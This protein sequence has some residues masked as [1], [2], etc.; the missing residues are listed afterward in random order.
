MFSLRAICMKYFPPCPQFKRNVHLRVEFIDW[1]SAKKYQTLVQSVHSTM[2]TNY[3]ACSRVATFYSKRYGNPFPVM[4]LW[5]AIPPTA[6]MANRPF[7]SS[8]ARF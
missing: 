3:L 8:E 5:V 1:G 7:K 4:M 6:H 2:S